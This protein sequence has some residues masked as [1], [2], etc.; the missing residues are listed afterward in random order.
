MNFTRQPLALAVLSVIALG[1]LS[2][3]AL[4]EEAVAADSTDTAA[5]A[6]TVEPK[7]DAEPKQ[8]GAVVVTAQ[9]RKE[10]LQKVNAAVSVVSSKTL[11]DSGVGRSANEVTKYIP[12]ASA[13]TSGGNT[14]PRWW[15]RGVGTGTQGLDSP[16]PVGVYLDDVYISNASATAFPLFD[17]ERVEVLRGPQGTLWGKNTTG[18]AINFISKK[19][20]FKQDG[21][22]RIDLSSD[23]SQILQGAFGGA[24]SGDLAARA[25]FFHENKDGQ[26]DNIYS[27]KQSGDAVNDAGRV[28]LLFNVSPTLEALLNLHY[29][30]YQ[31]AG[32]NATV[33]GTGAGGQYWNNQGATYTPSTAWTDVA[34]NVDAATRIKQ[35]GAA[36]NL[37]WKLDGLEAV[38]ITAFEGFETGTLSD[39]DNTPLEL[40]RGWSDAQTHQFSQEFRLATPKSE[41]LSW[42]AG[43]HYFTDHIK[44]A[45]AQATLPTADKPAGRALAWN[46][47]DFTHDSQSYAL[48]GNATYRFTDTFDITAGLRWSKESK[49][50]DLGRLASVSPAVFNNTDQW[51]LPTSVTSTRNVTATQKDS[52]SW[53]DLTYDLTPAYKISETQRVFLHVAKGFR[54][55][56]Y[57]SAP[58]TQ[59]AVSVLEPE[60]LTSY[61]IGYKSEWL[62]SRLNFNT[63]VFTYD[64]EDIQINAVTATPTGALSQLRNAASGKAT[65]AEV[66]LEALATSRLHIRGALGWLDTTFEDFKDSNGN[67]SG[68]RF[69]RSPEFS[70]VLN[71]DYKLPLP[72]G[73]AVVLATDW[74]YT[75]E[76][77]FYTNN[78]TDATLKQDGFVTGSA[79]VSWQPQGGKLTVTGYVNNLT[80]EQYKAHT[81]PGTATAKGNT[82]YWSEPRT[83]GVALTTKF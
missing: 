64:Y 25:A 36:L 18:G 68:N 76:Y 71:L 22:A 80:N 51:W 82:V 50:I 11:L 48:F 57:N 37:K 44:S 15:I 58:T 32:G 35:Q 69:V 81:L 72:S 65:G 1:G 8:L 47:T 29:R 54:G 33:I 46:R 66:E 14:R 40:S 42:V 2:P 26:F 75:S 73:A 31:I 59:A 49:D 21:Y 78:Q 3:Y 62:E 7:A 19:P 77:F 23:G 83:Y 13:G 67:Y 63:S 79:R 27:G 55:G 6:E 4:A 60:Y 24:V 16:S 9:R 12:N 52:R 70:G 17:V 56:G 10:N 34:S 74:N 45:S 5:T 61:E 20:S 41:R 53:D 28:Q 38:S 43:L 30:N 39:G